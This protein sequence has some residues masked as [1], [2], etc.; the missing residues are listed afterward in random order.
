[1]GRCLSVKARRQPLSRPLWRGPRGGSRRQHRRCPR[2]LC[3]APATDR[4]ARARAARTRA[5][6]GVPRLALTSRSGCGGR[7][8]AD[9]PP[10]AGHRRSTL[11]RFRRFP[12]PR[13]AQLR[14]HVSRRGGIAHYVSIGKFTLIAAVVESGASGRFDDLQR[15]RA[16]TRADGSGSTAAVAQ[17]NCRRGNVCYA[18]CLT[19]V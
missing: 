5:R 3:E 15:P 18:P 7:R 19:P 8:G 6:Q 13:D 2:A 10:R 12:S 17:P 4:R 11:L 1:M 14:T 9:S 16:R